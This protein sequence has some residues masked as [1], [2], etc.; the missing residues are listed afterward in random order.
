[1]SIE[2]GSTFGWHKWVG[3]KGVAIGIDEFG[4]SAPGPT[5]YEKFGITTDA[6]V[7][8]AKSIA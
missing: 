5:L 3:D 7:N 6:V 4:A 8:A 1:M 2:A